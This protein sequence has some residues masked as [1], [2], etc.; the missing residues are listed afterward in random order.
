MSMVEPLP[1]KEVPA[2]R[3]LQKEH[4]EERCPAEIAVLVGC[5][6]PGEGHDQNQKAGAHQIRGMSEP[7][8]VLLFGVDAALDLH[9][10]IGARLLERELLE[11]VVLGE[12]LLES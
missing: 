12:P 7:S 9:R 11:N 10:D 2:Q 6:D 8:V 5:S 1:Q 3:V 4:E